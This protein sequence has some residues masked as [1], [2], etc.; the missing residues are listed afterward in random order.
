MIFGN[1]YQIAIWVDV[2]PEWSSCE[3]E[4]GCFARDAA[5]RA[6][7]EN[8]KWVEGILMLLI[9]G[10]YLNG[11]TMQST[12]LNGEW[13][14]FENAVKRMKEEASNTN[15]RTK[16][17][18]FNS[19]HMPRYV[20]Y[21][22]DD[23]DDEQA[24]NVEVILQEIRDHGWGAYKDIKYEGVEITP[25]QIGDYSWHVYHFVD[26]E[27]E[28]LVY[29][30]TDSEEIYEKRMPLGTTRAVFLEAAKKMRIFDALPGT[31]VNQS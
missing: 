2:V 25:M 26:H 27:E 20:G 9:D 10:R 5:G 6:A 28:V 7:S 31:R 21:E 14:C 11:K 3:V 17:E 24:D 22:E 4:F 8:N 30:H 15:G 16:T 1:P 12:T 29:K 18:L 13:S 19:A 23:K